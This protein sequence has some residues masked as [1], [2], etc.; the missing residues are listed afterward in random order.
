MPLSSEY[1]IPNEHLNPGQRIK[2][3]LEKVIKTSKGPQLLISR[4]H[5]EL[6]RKLMEAEIPEIQ[7]GAVEIKAIAREA[8]VRCKVAVYSNDPKIDPVG[9]SVG[10]KG[11]RIQTITNEIGNERI[12][13]IQWNE[14]PVKFLE[15]ALAPATISKILIDKK[16]SRASVY[17]H[18]DQRALAI[19]KNGQNVRLASKLTRLEV[20]IL[21]VEATENI[22]DKIEAKTINE[23]TDFSK[24]IIEK[25]TKA[26]LSQTEQIKGLS[27]KD[28]IDIGLTEDEAKIVVEIMKKVR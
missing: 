1:R 8:G 15:A 28:F 18:E 4:T 19:G 9:S 17:V 3:Y 23:I 14:D 22:S 24:E 11:V 26:N 27:V 13:I 7:D 2:L 25:L 10:Q 6:I 12:D 16:T 20:D 21:D 5:P